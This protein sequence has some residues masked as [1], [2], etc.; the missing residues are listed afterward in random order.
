MIARHCGRHN[1]QALKC[2]PGTLIVFYFSFKLCGNKVYWGC[3]SASWH[4]QFPFVLFLHLML[5]SHRDCPL[6]HLCCLWKINRHGGKVHWLICFCLLPQTYKAA[7]LKSKL[8][9]NHIIHWNIYPLNC[10][11]DIRPDREIYLGAKCS[12]GHPLLSPKI[13]LLCC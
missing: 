11:E 2:V 4:I 8:K 9:A 7:F 6:N 1:T 13:Q 10:S 5:W 12:D 3:F